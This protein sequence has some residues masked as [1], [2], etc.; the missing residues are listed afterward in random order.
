MT[1][2][3]VLQTLRMTRRFAVTPER[4]FDAWTDPAIVARWLFTGPESEGHAAE[5]DARVGGQWKIIDRRGGVDYTAVGEYREV[6]RPRRLV[7]TFGMPQFSPEFAT[8]TVEIEP[9]GEGAVMTLIQD[10]MAPDAIEPT[11]QGWSL[12]FDGLGALLTPA[13]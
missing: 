2:N 12:M 4:L 6:D 9:D 7:F 11:R 1:D 10:R 8:V 13:P 5:L 3:L